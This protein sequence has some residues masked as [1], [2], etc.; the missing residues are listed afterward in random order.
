PK[1]VSILKTVL[2]HPDPFFYASMILGAAQDWVVDLLR[3]VFYLIYSGATDAGKGT[4]VA[5]TMALCRDGIVLG[6]ASGPYLRD[7]LGDGR[8]V[9]ISEF[10][11]LLK[12]N[13][14]LLAVVRNGN[15]RD[16]SKTGLKIPAGKGWKNADVDTF[17]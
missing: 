5:A 4:A 14:Q 1:A 9:G 15:R 17:G 2:D 12:E 8:A 10:E 3:T 11:T 16:T 7:T 6:G 13:A